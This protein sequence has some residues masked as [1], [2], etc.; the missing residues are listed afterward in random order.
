MK[1]NTM[2]QGGMAQPAPVQQAPQQPAK[3]PGGSSVEDK[4]LNNID[5]QIFDHSTEAIEESLEQ[6]DNLT[7]TI[8]EIA[9]E[10]MQSQLA[11]MEAVGKSMDQELYNKAGAEIVERLTLMAEQMGLIDTENP[12]EAEMIQSEALNVASQLFAQQAPQRFDADQLNTFITDAATGKFDDAV[13]ES[14]TQAELAEV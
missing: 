4:F 1:Q 11:S 14:D 2:N 13:G 6:S 7:M 3:S 9:S 12:Q 5:A 10:I 8:G